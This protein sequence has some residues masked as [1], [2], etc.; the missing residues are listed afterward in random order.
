MRTDSEQPEITRLREENHH[1]RTLLAARQVPEVDRTRLV[2]L[3]LQA[4]A[5][6]A[7]LRGP[8]HVFERVNPPYFQLVGQRNLLGKSVREAFPEIEGQGFFEILDEVYRTGKPFIGKDMRIVFQDAEDAPMREHYI[9]FV[10]QPLLESDGSVSGIL[11]HGIDWTERKRAELALRTSEE[12]FRGLADNIAQLAWIAD[13]TGAIIWYN[14]RWFDYTGTTHEEMQGWGWKAV[15]HPDYV[16]RVTEKFVHALHT[17]EAWEDTF[18]LCGKD[19]RYRWFLSRAAPVRND[20]GKVVRWFGTNTDVTEQR[21]AEEALRERQAEI[22]ALNVRLARAMQETHH[23]VKNNLQVIA[24]I[25]D[26]EQIQSSDTAHFQRINQHV[27]ALAIIH[28]L[29]TAQ[30]QAENPDTSHVS[31]QTV[32]MQLLAMLNLS[33]GARQVRA[34]IEDVILSVHKSSALALV[35]NECVSNALKHGEG[36]INVTLAPYSAKS[37]ETETL[38]PEIR[39]LRLEVCDNGTGFSA[40][41]DPRQAANTGLELIESTARWDLRGDVSFQNRQEGGACVVVTFPLTAE[42]TDRRTRR[43]KRN[44]CR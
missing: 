24:A 39:R 20:A 43:R 28:D 36:D 31:A 44:N 35:V 10:Y 30:A 5:F 19:G 18:P 42:D 14:R 29:L 9:D 7:V 11:A 3:L 21:E 27:Q 12:R 2:D 41:F 15:H 32:L 8:Q 13:E 40:G 37:G 23:R 1:L 4:P 33:S 38:Q 34:E 6:I 17:G 26:M 25:I 22:E 16:E